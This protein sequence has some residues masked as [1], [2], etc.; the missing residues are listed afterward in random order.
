[1][2]P[3][4]N[5]ST[6]WGIRLVS[7]SE[8]IDQTPGGILLHG[9]MSSIAEFYSKN[10][11]NEVVKGMSE[12][13][14]NGG[15][16]GR[17]PLG[18]L[19]VR[20]VEN[21]RENRIVEIDPDRHELITWAFQQYA[22]GDWSLASLASELVTRGLTTVQTARLPS[23]P[24]TDKNLHAILTNPV[25]TGIVL[26]KGAQYPGTHQPLVDNET[27]QKVQVT[28]STKLKGERSRKHDHFLKS[29][30]YCGECGARLIITIVT[31]HQGV[32]Y[33]YFMCSARQTKKNRCQFRSVRI[34]DVE[35]KMELLYRKIALTPAA[36]QELE[37]LA[38]AQ[39]AEIKKDTQSEYDQ[40]TE[41]KRQIK[42]QQQQLLQ[43]H[44][45]G[46]IPID[47]LKNEQDRLAKELVAV[48]SR[49]GIFISDL[50]G[51]EK[52]IADMFE[53]AENCAKAYIQ[54]PDHI[55]RTFNQVFFDKVYVVHDQKNGDTNL[56]PAFNPP[57]HLIYTMPAENDGQGAPS[58][59]N[60]DLTSDM[61][62]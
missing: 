57:L 30:L 62:S 52:L 40:L 37:T 2:S 59:T 58:L 3:S 54:A 48:E 9:I 47:I 24:I 49:L 22:T 13:A 8:N 16:V 21:G 7:T 46:A 10:L 44:Y 26:Y 56:A 33:P 18:Y 17:A 4:T 51:A 27:F 39:I 15:I 61:G 23:R 1:M 60:P 45:A 29:S 34:E 43:A 20:T 38:S 5:A 6:I 25:Y 53:L 50:A 19:N 41:Q 12:K 42:R 14:Q 35:E 11:S 32:K 31:N 55:K 28:L 36:R